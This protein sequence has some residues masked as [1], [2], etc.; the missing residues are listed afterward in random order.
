MTQTHRRMPRPHRPPQPSTEK[1][2][3]KGPPY[4]LHPSSV[5]SWICLLRVYKSAGLPFLMLGILPSAPKDSPFLPLPG[6]LS[7]P[8]TE[9][10][11]SLGQDRS[12]VVC[13][14]PGDSKS[15][16]QSLQGSQLLWAAGETPP[17]EVHQRP[18][19]KSSLFQEH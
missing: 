13:T 12:E 6:S 7:L 10:S 5:L 3:W 15:C 19:K 16:Y 9:Q 2:T 8:R 17:A 18:Q 11:Q 14:F 4:P 1:Y